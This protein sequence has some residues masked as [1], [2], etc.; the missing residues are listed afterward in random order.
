MIFNEAFLLVLAIS[1]SR[2]QKLIISEGVCGTFKIESGNQIKYHA[3]T[4]S[5]LS[6]FGLFSS[7]NSNILSSRELYYKTYD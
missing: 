7:Q 1:A 2:E 5:H 3:T 4:V 6:F